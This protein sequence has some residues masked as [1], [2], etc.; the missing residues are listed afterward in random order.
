MYL[1]PLWTTFY[2]WFVMGSNYV[3]TNC[4][5]EMFQL[6]IHDWNKNCGQSHLAWLWRNKSQMS[7]VNFLR[8]LIEQ[9][10]L[11]NRL[12]GVR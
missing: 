11:T 7:A 6:M 10:G 5:A 8:A 1:C 4:F 2:F 9:A 3:R 12:T